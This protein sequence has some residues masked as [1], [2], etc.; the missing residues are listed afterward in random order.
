M[1]KSKMLMGKARGKVGGLV[2]RVVSGVGQVVSEYN[3]H[4]AN[5]RTVGQTV[6]RGKMNVAGLLSKITPFDAIAG[7][8][9]RKREARSKFVSNILKSATGGVS[10]EIATTQLVNSK[11]KL[12][13]GINY[14]MTNT[15]TMDT[16]NNKLKVSVANANSNV[17]MAFIRIVAY[18]AVNQQ[19]EYCVVKDSLTLTGTTSQDVEI[20]FPQGFRPNVDGCGVFAIPIVTDNQDLLA[21]YAQSVGALE[22]GFATSVN[23]SLAQANAF[24]ES[25]MVNWTGGD[26]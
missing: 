15:A 4:P 16:S 22:T 24:G 14:E 7:L 11:L 17:S 23:V 5:P 13:D 6:Q 25:V 12:S 18:F 8:S 2:F 21:A 20:P 3:P 19:F 10:G 9:P 26:E 1:A